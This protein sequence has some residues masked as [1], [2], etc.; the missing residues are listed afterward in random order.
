MELFFKYRI[1]KNTSSRMEVI[2]DFLRQHGAQH[3]V[4]EKPFVYDLH[5]IHEGYA[6]LPE[7]VGMHVAPRRVS[8]RGAGN[9]R[10]APFGRVPKSKKKRSVLCHV[11]CC[12]FGW[13]MACV[14]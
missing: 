10:G 13:F 1:P 2:H 8:G 6:L 7:L 11:V 3:M 14:W 5:V 4:A 12:V 9:P